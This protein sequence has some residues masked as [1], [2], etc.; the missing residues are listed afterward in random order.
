MT[1][2]RGDKYTWRRH[3]GLKE[4]FEHGYRH[5]SRAWRDSVITTMQESRPDGWCV[6]VSDGSVTM[7]RPDSVLPALKV[8][9]SP[10]DIIA[11]VGTRKN[12]RTIH[13]DSAGS[14]CIPRAMLEFLQEHCNETETI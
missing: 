11:E 7:R 4:K 10:F 8:R 3:P 2:L 9:F 6:Y 13:I 14:N 12:P 5:Q 1:Q